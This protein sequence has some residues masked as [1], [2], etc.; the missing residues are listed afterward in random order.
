[1]TMGA[2]FLSAYLEVPSLAGNVGNMGGREVKC[3]V[4]SVFSKLIFL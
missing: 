2:W 3:K 4:Q 1:M